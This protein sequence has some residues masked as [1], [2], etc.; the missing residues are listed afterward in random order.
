MLDL[1]P[2]GPLRAP[3]DL[4]RSA[5][6][7]G[8]VERDG[9]MARLAGLYAESARGRGRWAVLRGPMGIGRST[10]LACFRE[11]VAE[12]GAITLHATATPRERLVPYGVLAQLV[13]S[14]A[15]PSALAGRLTAPLDALTAGTGTEPDPRHLHALAV[16]LARLA[17]TA[18]V[19]I[20]VDD[21]H[22]VDTASLHGLAALLP[23]SAAARILLVLA[24]RPGLAPPPAPQ[25][26]E[27]LTD[28]ALRPVVL[29][30]LSERGVAEV[31]A[32][33]LGAPAAPQTVRAFDQASG[34]NP[35]VLHCLLDAHRPDA[36][37]PV[38]EGADRAMTRCLRD[39]DEP[40]LA[41]VRAWAAL[42]PLA[43]RDRV[44]RL[45]G[46]GRDEVERV[47]H[48]LRDAGLAPD[49]DLRDWHGGDAVL[50]GLPAGTRRALHRRAAQVLRDEGVAACD[51]ATQLRQAGTAEQPAWAP[52]VLTAAAAQASAAGRLPDAVDFLRL[53]TAA[54]TGGGSATDTGGG[55]A[56]DTGGGGSAADTGGGS[57][58]E[59]VPE[60]A[61]GSV[62]GPAARSVA[63]FAVGSGARSVAGSVGVSEAGS[64]AESVT[65]SSATTAVTTAVTTAA[66]TAARS[67]AE[68]AALSRATLHAR[69]TR[70]EWHLAPAGAAGRLG[71][72]REDVLAGRCDPPAGVELVWQ[73]A[74]AGRLDE[75]DAVLDVLDG[76]LARPPHAAATAWLN[77]TYPLR[78]TATGVRPSGDPGPEA[79]PA[80]A[81]LA[82]A[83]V[84][85][86]PADLARVA[87]RVLRG[88]RPDLGTLWSTE[89]VLLALLCLISA[90]RFDVAGAWCD[91]QLGAP[92]VRSV[93][94]WSA[95]LTAVRAEIDLR[96]GRLSEAYDG[97][98]AALGTLTVPGWGVAAGLPLGCAVQAAVGMGRSDDAERLL[99][100]AVPDALPESRYGLHY[101]HARG[102]HR[103]AA[104]MEQ[105]ALA[106]F[107]S[108][109]E[110]TR[111]WGSAAIGLVSWRTGAAEAWLR[112]GN[113]EQARRLL[114]EQMAALPPGSPRARGLSLRM[115]AA[116]G[117]PG[118][119]AQLLTD[120]V[121]VLR[122]AGDTAELARALSDLSRERER[123]GDRQAAR[124]A[125]HRARRF[126][127]HSG[128]AQI[129][130]FCEP[131]PVEVPDRQ[132]WSALTEQQRRIAALAADGY[133]NREIGAR[134]FIT[135]STVEQHLTRIF[136]RL[137]VAGRAQ[138]TPVL[139]DQ[140]AGAGQSTVSSSARAARR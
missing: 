95:L 101:L 93:P 18:P 77:A 10:L 4:S 104:G 50:A 81:A 13:H 90:E 76:H 24:V 14:A 5:R 82:D 113:P 39:A 12:Q 130:D 53:A 61:A 65:E 21:A 140:A 11:A 37:E 127:R 121:E 92:R 69:L 66:T 91:R 98:T 59:S 68:S 30:P 6:A 134:L 117:P 120:A 116:A 88:V 87:E 99:A 55:S 79:L 118:R 63:G 97:A 112:Q 46:T 3:A 45:A 64:A 123:L 71:R 124:R 28:P 20:T 31:L 84:H 129:G 40:A 32:R 52:W 128:T 44:S 74:W 43:S 94:V 8:L 26:T 103:L 80:A 73:L 42:G 111:G 15:V 75:I 72:V 29:A 25:L 56:A 114:R 138:L 58:A 136:R 70:V 34:G 38:P 2:A 23:R 122:D 17:G 33:R 108:C 85:G 105:A 41:V 9:V 36:A 47:A 137:G 54:N 35:L 125:A 131:E 89:A 115:L 19:L 22:H 139:A 83:L 49:A 27:L 60:S 100:E 106:D 119:R 107:L 57:A 16:A 1:S 86:R 102:C 135:A 78:R 48:A 96:R 67:V 126:A 132:D 51:V 109:A 7:A 110:L 62:A 133:T